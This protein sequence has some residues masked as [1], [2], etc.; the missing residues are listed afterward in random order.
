[1]IDCSPVWILGVGELPG[2]HNTADLDG[3]A[4]E[5][6][7]SA[8]CSFQDCSIAMQFDDSASIAQPK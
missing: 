2:K 4:T 7:K 6:L 8:A 3:P 1:V 5:G